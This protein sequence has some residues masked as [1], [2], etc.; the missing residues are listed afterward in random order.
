MSHTLQ[1][2][3]CA[4]PRHATSDVRHH[5]HVCRILCDQCRL[6]V[7]PST[8]LVLQLLP[9]LQLQPGGSLCGAPLL[10]LPARPRYGPANPRRPLH[11]V[12]QSYGHAARCRRGH[13]VPGRRL[14]PLGAGDGSA[15]CLADCHQCIWY[16]LLLI[17]WPLPHLFVCVWN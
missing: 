12:C 5:Q 11:C 9:A 1:P 16:G 15:G 14:Q 8:W 6:N 4:V 3:L 7:L 2:G 13:S 17:H 10:Q